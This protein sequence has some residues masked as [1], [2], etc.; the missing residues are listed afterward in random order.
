MRQIKAND[1]HVMHVRRGTHSPAVVVSPLKDRQRLVRFAD[2]SRL[3][4]G[5]L[6]ADEKPLTGLIGGE[7]KTAVLLLQAVQEIPR[8]NCIEP[9]L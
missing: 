4:A 1:H 5:E 6:A 7:R 9:W 2:G 3:F 8:V